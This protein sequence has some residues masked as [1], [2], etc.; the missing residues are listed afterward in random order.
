MPHGYKDI[1]IIGWSWRTSEVIRTPL[2]LPNFCQN[3]TKLT[4]RKL[5]FHSAIT[6]CRV[7]RGYRPFGSATKS[8][9]YRNVPTRLATVAPS[10]MGKI[11]TRFH[12]I[13]IEIAFTI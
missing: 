12:L 9:L 10:V 1:L 13:M 11:K 5:N 6:L 3:Y 4:I 2:E 7:D 8:R